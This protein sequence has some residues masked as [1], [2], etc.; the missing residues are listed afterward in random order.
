MNNKIKIIIIVTILLV[1]LGI[2][3]YLAK[4]TNYISNSKVS[5]EEE[6]TSEWQA[7]AVP[8]ETSETVGEQEGVNW[9][10]VIGWEETEEM[11][12]GHKYT[13]NSRVPTVEKPY[14]TSEEEGNI[15]TNTW[16]AEHNKIRNSVG[17]QPVKWNNSIANSAANYAKTCKFQHSS[18]SDRIF[19]P[20]K[21]LLGENL[22]M[23]TP[24]SNYSD[25]NIVSMWD[26]EKNIY[27]YPN[28]PGSTT[29]HYTQIINKNVT[30]IGCGCADC[31]NA[32][33]CVCRYNPIQLSNQPPY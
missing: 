2:S 16:T 31:N 4:Y 8:T 19:G 28:N 18:N 23:G 13:I 29:G 1:L 26:A 6:I 5:S 21:I 9:N 10:E 3:S 32:K 27:K 25:A 20:N 24:Y 14:Y 11:N 17:Q 12:P 7:A 22:G 15:I 30:E 33:Y